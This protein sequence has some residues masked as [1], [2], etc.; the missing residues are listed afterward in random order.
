MRKGEN[1]A[2]ATDCFKR[3]SIPIHPAGPRICPKMRGF[4]PERWKLPQ[5]QAFFRPKIGANFS[6]GV[7]Y[8]AENARI[9]C[10]EIYA[11]PT[12]F[13]RNFIEKYE[14]RRPGTAD[15]TSSMLFRATSLR[16]EKRRPQTAVFALSIVFRAI[17]LRIT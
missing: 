3:K 11:S 13:P 1:F 5:R 17:S 2:A 4:A 12:V 15:F 6:R 14:R 7:W 9:C 10:G 8:L 16:Y